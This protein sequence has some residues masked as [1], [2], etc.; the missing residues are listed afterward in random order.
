MSGAGSAGGVGARQAGLWTACVAG[1]RGGRALQGGGREHAPGLVKV[2]RGRHGLP[3]N[4][5]ELPN[6]V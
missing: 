2:A 3:P 4:G 5:K 6:C 1:L